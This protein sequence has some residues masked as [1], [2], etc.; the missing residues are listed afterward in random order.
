MTTYTVTAEIWH[1][2]YQATLTGTGATVAEAL[3]AIAS[4]Y[5]SKANETHNPQVIHELE[6]TGKSALGWVDY[7]VT[8][9]PETVLP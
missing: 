3:A 8:R 4:P 7:T 1:G 9:N 5:T 6:T 2:N